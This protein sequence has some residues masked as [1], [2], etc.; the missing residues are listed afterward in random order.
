MRARSSSRIRRTCRCSRGP[1]YSS[2]MAGTTSSRPTAAWRKVRRPCCARRTSTGPYE[3]RTVLAQGNTAVQAPH[4]GGYVETPDGEGWFAA[5]QQHRRLWP[6]RAPAAGALGGRLAAHGRARSPGSTT[7]GQPVMTHAMPDVG[8]SW[9]PVS[10]QTSDEFADAEVR[11]AVGVEPQPARC[12]LEPGGERRVSCACSAMP[13]TDFARGAQYPDAGAA[14]AGDAYHHA[15]R[16]RRHARRPARRPRD[17][18]G[19]AHWI[20]VVQ[21]AGVTAHHLVFAGAQIAGPVDRGQL[22]CSCG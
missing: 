9:P 1:N 6:H 11:R 2:A 8:R 7:T 5:L 10:I 3:A 15:P 12:Q 4:Q 17:A 14:R 20:G 22:P 21:T 18:A 19:A 16:S 13:A